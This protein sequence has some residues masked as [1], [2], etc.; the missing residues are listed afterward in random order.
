MVINLESVFNSEGLSLPVDYSL[1]LSSET[2]GS[3]KPFVYPVFVKGRV[4]NHTGIV[5]IE[6]QASTHIVYP[7]DRCTAPTDF[8]LDVKINHILVTSVND[9][10]NDDFML[11]KSYMFNLDEIVIEDFFLSLPSKFLC[12]EDCKGL[13]F[14][15]GKNLNEGPCECKKE[16]DPRLAVL[17]QLLDS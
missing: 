11:I 12:S 4:F 10:N 13:C 5:E 8:D 16:I 1:D 7:C 9:E 15:C 14:K 2:L 3:E 17:S 6:A